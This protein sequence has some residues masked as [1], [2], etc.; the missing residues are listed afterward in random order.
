MDKQEMSLQELQKELENIQTGFEILDIRKERIEM[1]I[2]HKE[3][4]ARATFMQ[5]STI[6]DAQFWENEEDRAIEE[7]IIARDVK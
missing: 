5:S 1:E 6:L 2:C 4:L 7:M 3:E